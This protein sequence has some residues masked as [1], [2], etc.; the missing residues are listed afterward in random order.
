MGNSNADVM[1]MVVAIVACVLTLV[2]VGVYFL[3]RSVDKGSRER[4]R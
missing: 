2:F 4:Q 3:N 1:M